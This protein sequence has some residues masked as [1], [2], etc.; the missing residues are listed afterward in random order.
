MGVGSDM[1]A[2]L[3]MADETARKIVQVIFQRLS[4][5]GQVAVAEH[6]SVSEA[7]VSRM[8]EDMPRFAGML[9]KL[10]LK[11]VPVEMRC[12]DEKTL[13]SILMLAQQRMAQLQTPS[14]LAQD[15][16]QQ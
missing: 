4:S 14:Q 12:Y 11:V 9:S 10:G 7:T 8:K 13:A 2:L 16:D 1:A 15:W 6:L 3:P 5:V